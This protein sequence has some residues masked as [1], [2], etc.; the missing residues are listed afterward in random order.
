MK[1][2][3]TFDLDEIEFA[4]IEAVE[5]GATTY[6][7]AGYTWEA[8]KR[9]GHAPLYEKKFTDAREKLLAIAAQLSS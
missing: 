5:A 3:A 8:L 6:H 9:C 1:Q 7:R 4:L 2:P